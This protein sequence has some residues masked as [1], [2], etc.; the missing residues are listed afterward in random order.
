MIIVIYRTKIVGEGIISWDAYSWRESLRWASCCPCGPAWISHHSRH[1]LHRIS[2]RCFRGSAQPSRTK[3][4]RNSLSLHRWARNRPNASICP[5]RCA[6][7][8]GE[9]SYCRPPDP[10][11]SKFTH[12]PEAKHL[13]CRIACWLTDRALPLFSSIA[14]GESRLLNSSKVTEDS[15]LS[16]IWFPHRFLPVQTANI[17]TILPINTRNLFRGSSRPSTKLTWGW[18]H[19]GCHGWQC[20]RIENERDAPTAST[21]R[22]TQCK[23]IEKSSILQA[24][25]CCLSHAYVA[26]DWSTQK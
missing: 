12:R 25:S 2:K 5:Q 20:D 8:R 15:S 16:P 11:E 26:Y 17:P 10:L 18:V 9:V 19:R 7:E 3:S 21:P 4:S 6:C 14:E 24:K 13:R 1:T 22:R 23:P